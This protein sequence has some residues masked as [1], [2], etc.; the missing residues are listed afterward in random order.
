MDTP[1]KKPRSA[2][3]A[4]IFVTLAIDAIGLGIILPVLPDVV[5]KF[6]AHEASVAQIY[7]Y[8]IAVYA[9]LQF[10]SS[11][12][13]GRLS[14]R[15]GR[16]PILLLSLFGAGIDYIFMAFAPTL[17]LLFVGRVIAGISGASFT[18]ASAYI[19]D[20][21]DD[22]NRSK[23]F[24]VL[25][26][27]FGIGFI[28]G[29]AIGGVLATHGA[30]MPF[31]AAAAFNLLN[32]AF[33]YFVLPESLN[34]ERRRNFTLRD[35]NPLKSLAALAR[36][37]AVNG[38]IFAYVLMQLAGH[39]HPSIWTLYTEH[40]YGW[41]AAQVGIS[42]AVVGILSALSQGV[43]TGPLVAR[44][45]ERRVIRWGSF[46]EFVSFTLF[47]LAA[48]GTMLY[49]VLVGSAI[50]WAA[51]PALQALISKQIPPNE[52]GELQG[53]LMS[54]TS[55]TA[56]VNPLIMTA[57]FAATSDR[58]K[59]VYFPG[60]PYVVAAL[61]FFCAWLSIRRWNRRHGESSEMQPSVTT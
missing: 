29:P 41:S 52:Q 48:T 31:L 34:A 60:S 51:H 55:L 42:F 38:L 61:L 50:F 21:S 44:F 19:A 17:P 57:L 54:L 53:A 16:R 25:G 58:S 6:V 15:Y 36:M 32:F 49:V 18:V 33:G 22:S 35:L 56:I 27:G 30:M 20:I 11:P 13:L 39:T 28:L 26:A 14:D 24:G 5:R 23:N 8:F 12:L 10:V 46:G 45:G 7:G 47:G 2:S 3:I 59:D 1:Q 4:F 37:P 43:L 9:L 40:R